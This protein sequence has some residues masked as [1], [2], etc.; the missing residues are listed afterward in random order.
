MRLTLGT[1]LAC[2]FLAV[3]L[4]PAA[5][6]VFA[7]VQL[8]RVN[9]AS[10]EIAHDW[11]P[12][13]RI[14]ETVKSRTME[15]RMAQFAHNL[16]ATPAEMT[17][18]ERQMDTLRQQVAAAFDEYERLGVQGRER[19]LFDSVKRKWATYLDDNDR[20]FL[21]FSRQKDNQAT[22]QLTG[23]SQQLF[24]GINADLDLLVDL[25]VSSGQEASGRADTIFDQSS[26]L[27]LISIGLAV[28][29]A[30]G[31]GL[32]VARS[33][34]QRVARVASA[35]NQ[36]AQGDLAQTLDA[37]GAD[38]IGQM[39]DAFGKMASH[40]RVQIGEL[41]RGS[42]SL[43]A[44]ASEILA[45]AAEQAAGATEQSAAIAETTA[46]VDQVRASADQAVQTAVAVSETAERA[47][48]VA[49]EGVQAVQD[50][51]VGMAEIRQKVQSIAENI[52][53]LSE[54]TQQIG[55]IIASVND[56]ADQSNLLALNAAIEAGRAG[57]HG[58][59]FAVVATEIRSLAEQ[60]KGATAQIKTILSDIQRATHAA[61]MVT[62]QGTKGVDAGAELIHQAGQ[63]IDKLADVSQQAAH[64]AHQIAA[65][66]RQ[67][68]AGM[69]QIALAMSN[70]NQATT[71][72]LAATNDT[73]QAAQ[74]IRDLASHL[75]E[76]VTQYRV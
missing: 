44:A 35:A 8:N 1:K 54:Q 31:L 40:L 47:S 51:T 43:S 65:A 73:R 2:A 26:G 41:Q 49:N 69:E 33:I 15:F 23:R 22:V 11:L 50:A 53:A 30:L 75:D 25:N 38:E 46:T 4:I 34:S 12:S 63:T 17:S 28:V 16:A 62:E 52:L 64:S 27:I 13:L 68:S 7:I 19:P 29:V 6:G 66:V 39:A 42:H 76:L 18:I 20:T 36:L 72:S 58:K 61:V 55:E 48:Q 32:L 37:G 74:N 10:T 9:A 24:D 70:I 59:G 45:A 57:E 60:S 14:L 71:K 3:A 67:H 21:P 5:V 56:L